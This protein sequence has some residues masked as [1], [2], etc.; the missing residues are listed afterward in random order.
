MALWPVI[1]PRSP[2][3]W[4][5]RSWRHD[6][7]CAGVPLLDRAHAQKSLASIIRHLRTARP[8]LLAL[9]VDQISRSGAFFALLNRQAARHGLAI[10]NVVDYH[11]AALIAAIRPETRAQDLLS[12][13][14][15]KELNRQFRRLEE[16]GQITFQIATEGEELGR[17]IDSFLILESKGWKGRKGGA[18]LSRRGHATFARSMMRSLGHAGKCRVFSLACGDRVIS[19][20]IVLIEQG[21]AYFWKT[22]FDEDFAAFSPGVLLTLFMTETFLNESAFIYADSC[23]IPDH[24]MIGHIWR[25]KKDLSDMVISL[26]PGANWFARQMARRETLIRRAREGAKLMLGR[27]RP[28]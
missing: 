20:N 27:L 11:R 28:F 5:S 14:K 2:F 24:S 18:F 8:R 13:K 12:P 22:A 9:S 3:G 6:Y 21:V 4:F 26:R 23:A 17:Q 1:F 15:R 16:K 19:Y 7:C 25:E 10:E